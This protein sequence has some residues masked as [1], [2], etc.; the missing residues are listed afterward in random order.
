MLLMYKARGVW[1][2]TSEEVEA[3]R[4]GV[5]KSIFKHSL[6][7]PVRALLSIAQYLNMLVAFAFCC[8]ENIYKELQ[9]PAVFV[10]RGLR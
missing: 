3:L 7:S 10:E 2:V 9:N 8:C 4:E 1:R 5:K 6:P